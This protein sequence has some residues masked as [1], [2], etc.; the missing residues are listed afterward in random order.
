MQHQW[1]ESRFLPFWNVNAQR[2]A[3]HL[4]RNRVIKNRVSPRRSHWWEGHNL[5]EKEGIYFLH[6]RFLNP[7]HSL[8]GGAGF[9]VE[10]S[11]GFHGAL[12]PAVGQMSS[13]S[14]KLER[15]FLHLLEHLS[16]S[17]RARCREGRHDVNVCLD[18]AGKST[19]E[20]AKGKRGQL[21]F[22]TGVATAANKLEWNMTTCFY[23]WCCFD[24]H[25]GENG[26]QEGKGQT[27]GNEW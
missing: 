6:Q 10:R 20:E 3:E 21:D 7:F 13:V 11:C 9:C 1:I 27:I 5:R 23:L 25:F 17:C 2:F 16:G 22:L 8:S 18:D 26:V 12:S 4:W 24:V 14:L 15:F 19:R